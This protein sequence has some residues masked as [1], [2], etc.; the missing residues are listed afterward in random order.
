MTKYFYSVL[1]Y[2][3]L[4]FIAM[5]MACDGIPTHAPA[6][7]ELLDGTIPN[8]S[9]EQSTRHLLGDAAFNDEVF[10][11]RTGL[12]PLFVASTC[13]AC[14]P[15]DGR[16]HLSTALIR[17]G[18][19]APGVNEWIG[20]G[21]PQL[22]QHALPGYD[23]EQLPAGVASS[24]F[25]A[26]IA[27]GLG[28]LDAVSDETILEYADEHDV[29]GDGISGRPSRIPNPGY[30]VLRKNANVQS[31]GLIGR[32]GRKASAY[33]LLHQ[34]AI[35]YNQD[36]GV[37]SVF[38]PVDAHS[39]VQTDAEV[40]TQT[41][42][43]VVFY[44]QTLKAPPRRNA[45]DPTV[46]RGEQVFTKVGCHECHRASMTTGYSPIV[47]LSEVTFSPYTDLLLHN[48]GPELDD[49]YTE[50]NAT[51]DEWRTTPL[52][53]LGLASKS[54]GG[55]MFLLHDGRA[56]SITEAIEFHGGEGAKARGLFRLLPAHEQQDLVNFLLSL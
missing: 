20:R 19:S 11:R 15:G 14:H 24:V 43:N 42:N 32:F 33:D 2:V 7:H 23:A 49:G 54:Q 46:M 26:P 4:L 17:F 18:Q 50:N 48:M 37:T 29:N 30:L 35:A 9:M 16:G 25:L 51:S 47:G 1:N 56:R 6:D 55:T 12:G 5:L 28:F 21:G 41:V 3:L 34:T 44:L 38:E 10:T 13:G 45:S 53:G 36:L 39:N 52:W 40:S 27:T 31:S 22:Q 8:L